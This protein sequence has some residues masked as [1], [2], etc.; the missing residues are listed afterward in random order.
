MVLQGLKFP[1]FAFCW[2]NRISVG[3]F[4]EMIFPLRA[5]KDLRK[6]HIQLPLEYWRLK[7]K[8][9]RKKLEWEKLLLYP[10]LKCLPLRF[11]EFLGFTK[12][13]FSGKIQS[14]IE[15]LSLKMKLVCKSIIFEY[16]YT[17]NQNYISGSKNYFILYFLSFIL[18]SLCQKYQKKMS[19]SY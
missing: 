9:Q 3:N 15:S 12:N 2:S 6:I 7:K 1:F 13:F 11:V 8:K 4:L 17:L 16:V 18:F 5:L 10:L 19:K 14:I